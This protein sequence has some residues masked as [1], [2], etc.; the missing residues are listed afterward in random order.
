M[1]PTGVRPSCGDCHVSERLLPAMWDHFLG[2]KELVVHFATDVSKPGNYDEN[3]RTASAN[4][5]RLQ[6]LANDSKNCRRCH[7]MKAITPEHKHGQRLHAEAIE[8]KTTCI[9]CHYNLVHKE[10]EP[11]EAFLKAIDSP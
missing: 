10:V 7:V 8:N 2:M 11:S 4:H 1:T 5:V 3:C 9:V 6:M